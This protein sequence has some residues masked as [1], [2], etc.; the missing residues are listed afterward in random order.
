MRKPHLYADGVSYVIVII[1]QKDKTEELMQERLLGTSLSGLVEEVI[2]T[3]IL[4]QKLT[5]Q[6]NPHANIYRMTQNKTTYRREETL[7]YGC[8]VLFYRTRLVQFIQTDEV[9]INQFT[10]SKTPLATE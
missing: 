10:A 1:G 8:V 7:R 9:G 4:P 5:H 6:Y 3:T 2:T